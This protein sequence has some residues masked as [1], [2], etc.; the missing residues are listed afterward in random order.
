MPLSVPDI[1]D[2]TYEQL[3]A[4]ARTLIPKNFPV[5]TD[6]NPSDPGITLLELFAFLMEAGIYQINRVPEQSLEHFAGLMGIKRQQGEEIEQMLCRAMKVLTEKSRAITTE[7]MIYLIQQP[8]IFYDTTTA[9]KLKY[10]AG[11]PVCDMEV[12]EIIGSISVWHDDGSKTLEISMEA[13]KRLFEG[14]VILFDDKGRLECAVVERAVYGVKTTTV[15]LKTSTYFNHGKKAKIR[16]I[17]SPMD[18]CKSS[19]AVAVKQGEK[20]IVLKN[21]MDAKR[22][23]VFRVGMP[24]SCDY[25]CVNEVNISRVAVESKK[26]FVNLIIVPYSD[27]EATPQPSDDLRQKVFEYIRSICPVSTRIRV[28][29][30]EYEDICIHICAVR[31]RGSIIDK[32]MLRSN[33]HEAVRDFLNPLPDNAGGKGWEF[34]RTV[35]RS[36]LYRIIEDV[37]GVDHVKQLLLKKGSVPS[38]NKECDRLVNEI[39]LTTSTSLVRVGDE[40]VSIEVIDE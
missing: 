29:K 32:G 4:E 3:V 12:S 30:P 7:D 20:G 33:I 9:L 13:G 22:S 18:P 5:W 36:E 27:T 17:I 34:G 37:K 39:C 16:K 8:G 40:A 11:T 10:F 19:L 31:E 25:L 24:D 1:D 14:D 2:R 15:V 35:Y 21:A 38:F 26:D 23:Y 6:H 28:N